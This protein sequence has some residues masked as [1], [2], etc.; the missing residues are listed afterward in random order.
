MLFQMFWH[1]FT[2]YMSPLLEEF[3]FKIKADCYLNQ[4]NRPLLLYLHTAAPA[5]VLQSNKNIQIKR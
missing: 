5:H 3:G 1:L 2:D 4:F